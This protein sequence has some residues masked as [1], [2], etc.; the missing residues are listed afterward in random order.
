M[1]ERDS[2]IMAQSL[3]QDG[4]SESSS[5]DLADIIILNTCS[6]REKA[7][8]KVIS[9]LGSLRKNKEIN[10]NC[11]ICVAGCVAQQE[12]VRILEKMP[13]VDLIIGTQHIYSLADLLKKSQGS[14]KIIAN[15]LS[16]AYQIPPFLPSLKEDADTQEFSRFVT[17][18]QGCNNFC[19]YCVVPYTRGREISRK[20]EDILDEVKVLV[21]GGVTDITLLGQNVNSYGL[22]N[23][24]CESDSPYLFADLLRETSQIAGLRRLRFTTSH[25]KDLSDDLIQSFANT[26]LLCPQFH[27]PV[28][29]GSN[30]IL[31]R[32]NRK[33]TRE[34][35]LRLVDKLRAAQP[36]IALST[37]I[38]VGFPGE[39]D[40]DFQCTLDLLNE[41]KF[42]S[43]FSFKYSDRPG[44]ASSSFK[45]KIPEK[46]K[47]ERLRIFQARQDEI[48]LEKNMK[49]VGNTLELLVESI[50]EIGFAGRSATNHLVHVSRKNSSSPRRGEYVW[51]KIVHAG[52]HSLKGELPE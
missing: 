32:M 29:S 42:H 7:E 43:S 9:L 12:G 48:S 45:D 44:T 15:Q 39:T 35:Y 18:M 14:G 26:P 20:K 8:H 28:Q 34:Q 31:S 33:Y 13:F 41:V 4:H 38:I 17:I 51:A 50:S 10:K 47:A 21:D 11:I 6:I 2:E 23:S 46:V 36:E 37:D 30:E 27:L 22:A 3:R 16:S 25:P 19:T 1:N 40:A 5:I 52:K 24:V 49:Y